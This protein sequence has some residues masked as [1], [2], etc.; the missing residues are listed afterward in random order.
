MEKLKNWFKKLFNQNFEDSEEG[1]ITCS[2]D[3]GYY[4]FLHAIRLLVQSDTEECI[5]Y[6]IGSDY[7]VT[8][9]N[10]EYYGLGR[11][12][13]KD[14]IIEEV[15]VRIDESGNFRHYVRSR[16]IYK[17]TE[18]DLY[19][20][21]IV[22]SRKDFNESK[23][24]EGLLALFNGQGFTEEKQREWFDTHYKLNKV[25]GFKTCGSGVMEDNNRREK[26]SGR[27]LG[28]TIKVN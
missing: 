8:Y 11:D 12:R 28:Y 26:L 3:G 21:W 14:F 4:S 6:T 20:N 25:I 24:P 18:F 13:S 5:M 27:I 23:I 17:P 9:T 1:G 22:V 10:L 16:K 2:Y 7:F 15:S 19:N